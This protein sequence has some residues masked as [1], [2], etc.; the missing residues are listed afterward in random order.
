MSAPP[1]GHD[2]EAEKSA[3]ERAQE[4]RTAL[5]KL[6]R[7]VV[8]AEERVVETNAAQLL[9][10]NEH[11]VVSSL[12][13]QADSEASAKMIRESSRPA[14]LDELTELPNRATLLGRFALALENAARK[15]AQLALLFLDLDNF[16]EIN[17]TLGH[18][19]GDLALRRAAQCLTSAVR[20]GDTVSRHGGDEFLILLAEVS[21][22]SDA[23]LVAEKVIAALGAPSRMGDHVLRL[24][25]SIGISVYPDDGTDAATLIERADAAMYIAKKHGLGSFVL[26][27]H[28]P[29]V[30]APAIASTH[31]TTGTAFATL[32]SAVVAAPPRRPAEDRDDDRRPHDGPQDREV[33]V[34]HAPDEHLG[35]AQRA[36]D[37]H[38][39]QGADEAEGDGPQAAQV[40]VAHDGAADGS[41]DP[42]DDEKDEEAGERHGKASPSRRMAPVSLARK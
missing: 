34:P 18:A 42:G 24:Q 7:E 40:A 23:I 2:T 15:N 1:A 4:A 11:L 38:A 25:A 22:G 6:H 28:E 39:E 30:E 13:A 26:H 19:V 29:A 27:G 35:Q 14:E 17:D 9:Q 8:E 5:T 33:L 20:G 32:R 10:A 36:R 3:G 12:L 21:K 41:A 16:K 31:S 37:P